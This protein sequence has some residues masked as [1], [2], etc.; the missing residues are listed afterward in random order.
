MRLTILTPI[1]SH[2]ID[3]NYKKMNYVCNPTSTPPNERQH[4][5]QF[6]QH[7]KKEMSLLR[8]VIQYRLFR[9]DEQGEKIHH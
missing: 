5:T 8:R 2:P 6:D 7:V 1:I 9:K 3:F 4:T